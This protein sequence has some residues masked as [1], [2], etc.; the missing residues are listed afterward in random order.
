MILLQVVDLSL[1]LIQNW[2]NLMRPMI[3]VIWLWQLLK[4]YRKLNLNFDLTNKQLQLTNFDFTGFSKKKQFFGLQFH[5][6]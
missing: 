6:P 3:L 2:K 5:K 4:N 1:N